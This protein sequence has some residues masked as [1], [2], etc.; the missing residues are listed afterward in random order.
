MAT[1]FSLITIQKRQTSELMASS[2]PCLK[3]RWPSWGMWTPTIMRWKEL[4]S[5]FFFFVE[6]DSM[7]ESWFYLTIRWNPWWVISIAGERKRRSVSDNP[8]KNRKLCWSATTWWTRQSRWL[9]LIFNSR[10]KYNWTKG[11]FECDQKL[12]LIQTMIWN[13]PV[14]KP[15]PWFH[16]ISTHVLLHSVIECMCDLYI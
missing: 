3:R 15:R 16:L 4:E 6:Y 14:L 2:A 7:F 9:E 8:G 10:E 5:V 1:I 13:K 11:D 12:W